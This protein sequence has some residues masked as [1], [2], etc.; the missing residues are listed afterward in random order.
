MIFLAMLFAAQDCANA[1]AQSN[2]TRCAVR[3]Y[4]TADAALNRQWKTT[5]ATMR[6]FDATPE[7][8][9]RPGY[10]DQLLKAQRAWL[11]YRDEHC[12]SAGYAMRGGSAEPMVVASCRARLTEERTRQLAQLIRE[13]G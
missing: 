4:E 1:V 6:R 9:G 8:D 10:A 13:G 7:R 5:L 12:R 11:S 3:A 2:M